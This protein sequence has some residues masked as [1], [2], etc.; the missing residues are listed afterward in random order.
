[1]W[2]GGNEL[3]NAWSGMTEQAFALRLLNSNCYKYDCQTPFLMTAPVYG[4]GH[5]HYNNVD[6]DGTEFI[7]TLIQS[8]FSAYTEFGCPGSS[9][10]EYIKS[11]MSEEEFLECK[12]GTVWETHHAF[13]AWNAVDTWLRISEVEYYFDGYTDTYDLVEKCSIIQE[14]NYKSYFEEIRKHWPKCSMAINWCF[15]EP[16]P[17]AA[18]NS[19]VN[20]PAIPKKAYYSVKEALRP[21]MTSIRATKNFWEAGKAFKA[22]IWILN[23]SPVNLQ[24]QRINAYF[25]FDGSKELILTWIAKPVNSQNNLKGAKI[26]LVI[27]ENVISSFKIILESEENPLMNSSYTYLVKNKKDQIVQT[28]VLNM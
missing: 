19:I 23:D 11:F 27:P 21:Q 16:W 10:A 5:G 17:T 24:S 6:S 18:N 12:P 26:N 28:G 2:C 7:G 1:M 3:F 4:M 20:W 14:I 22:E 8:D 13:N 15:N 9:S 25:E